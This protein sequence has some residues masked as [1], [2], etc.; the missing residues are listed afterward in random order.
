MSTRVVA[1][2]MFAVATTW[3]QEVPVSEGKETAVVVLPFTNISGAPAD[4]WLSVGIAESIR[5]DVSVGRY[6]STLASYHAS[7]LA[8]NHTLYW[9]TNKPPSPVSQSNF[10]LVLCPLIIPVPHSG[11]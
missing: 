4:D 5:V 9:V 3:A 8:E 7:P 2:M 1:L 10:S 6:S 11:R